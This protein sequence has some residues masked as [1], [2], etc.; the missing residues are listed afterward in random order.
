MGLSQCMLISCTTRLAYTLTQ[1]A[2]SSVGTLLRSLATVLMRAQTIGLFR[3][4]GLPHGVM[5]ATSRSRPAVMSA[6]SKAKRSPAS[7]ESTRLGVAELNCVLTFDHH[8]RALI[9]AS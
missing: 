3:T 6:A 7:S 4:R 2:V 1:L 9:L 8:Y 5:E